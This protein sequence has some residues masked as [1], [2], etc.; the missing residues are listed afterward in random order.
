MEKKRLKIVFNA[1]VTLTFFGLCVV[2]TLLGYL[3]NGYS[4][5][6]SGGLQGAE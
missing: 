3:T 2:V 1:P 5:Q 6:L 4:T